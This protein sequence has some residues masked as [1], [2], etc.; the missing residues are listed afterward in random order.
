M[1]SKKKEQ[2]RLAA[3][4]KRAEYREQLAK[5]EEQQQQVRE[6]FGITG[7]GKPVHKTRKIN[8]KAFKNLY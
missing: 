8:H 7:H 3:E 4:A 1:S 2:K 6:N 5:H